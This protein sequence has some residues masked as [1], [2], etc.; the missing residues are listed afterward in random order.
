MTFY[1]NNLPVKVMR[2]VTSIFQL[3][4]SLG[5]VVFILMVGVTADLVSL[6]LTIVT[7]A[8][9]IL[10]LT[11]LFSTSILKANNKS[12]YEEALTSANSGSKLHTGGSSGSQYSFSIMEV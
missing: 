4:Q 12:F 3:I 10:L 11:V 2:R 1:Q 9:F 6:R 5:Q 7:L 8:L